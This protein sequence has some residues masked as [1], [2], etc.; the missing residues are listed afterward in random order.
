MSKPWRCEHPERLSAFKDEYRSVFPV[1][2]SSLETS[3]VSS[4]DDLLEPMLSKRHD[5]KSAKA[6]GRIRTLATQSL[7]AIER[8]AFQDQSAARYGIIAVSYIQQALG[9]LLKKNFS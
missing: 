9:S 3:Q 5:S 4:L 6:W 1:H 2:D 7:K 8:V